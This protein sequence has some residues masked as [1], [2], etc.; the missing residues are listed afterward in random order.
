[1]SDVPAMVFDD[2]LKR[3]TFPL[4]CCQHR[5]HASGGSSITDSHL[6]FDL[7]LGTRIEVFSRALAYRLFRK[8]SK[9]AKLNLPTTMSLDQSAC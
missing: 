5:L 8:R 9:I 7:L 4:Y 1:M 3:S 6:G 2:R